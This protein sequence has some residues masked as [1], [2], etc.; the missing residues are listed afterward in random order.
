MELPLM[1]RLLAIIC[2]LLPILHGLSAADGARIEIT[3]S[4]LRINDQDLVKS[5]KLSEYVA[6]LG[7]PSRSTSLQNVIHTYDELGISLYQPLGSEEIISIA[8][9][10]VQQSYAFSPKSPFRGT[11]TIGG[12]EVDGKTIVP[13][14]K[15]I[16]E[17][18]VDD[19]RT[20][21]LKGAYFDTAMIFRFLEMKSL[22]GLS[23]SF[24]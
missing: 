19:R 13:D 20:I 3:K 11:M 10:F 23:I 14:L 9:D 16:Q 6:A 15:K 21:V 24:R 8:L 4:G 18:E 5:S 7:K 12:T 2:A 17:L 22:E 1:F